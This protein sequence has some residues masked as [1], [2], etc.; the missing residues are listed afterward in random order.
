MANLFCVERSCVP[1]TNKTDITDA[2]NV[3]KDMS[4]ERADNRK[5]YRADE[6]CSDVLVFSGAL[7]EKK[8]VC[9]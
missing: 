8:R 9:S 1:G 5:N 2:E 7:H 4:Q 6:W 3:N